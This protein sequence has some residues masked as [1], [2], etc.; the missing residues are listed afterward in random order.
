M[1]A[2]II[3]AVSLLVLFDPGSRQRLQELIHLARGWLLVASIGV[4]LVAVSAGL[5]S[6]RRGGTHAVPLVLAPALPWAVMTTSATAALLDARSTLLQQPVPRFDLSPAMDAHVDAWCVAS[7]FSASCYAL[8]ALLLSSHAARK[9]KDAPTRPSVIEG[10]AA[11]APVVTITSVLVFVVDVGP[12]QWLILGVIPFAITGAKSVRASMAAMEDKNPLWEGMTA[13]ILGMASLVMGWAIGSVTLLEN[14]LIEV[15]FYSLDS[16]QDALEQAYQLAYVSAATIA[17][18]AG[19]ILVLGA[20]QRRRSRSRLPAVG[21]VTGAPAGTS[22]HTASTP[23]RPLI[24]WRRG[25]APALA[26]AALIVSHL[27]ALRLSSLVVSDAS[28]L[29]WVHVKDFVPIEAT[30][31]PTFGLREVVLVTQRRIVFSDGSSAPISALDGSGVQHKLTARFREEPPAAVAA[32]ARLPA[33]I[34]TS[35]TAAAGA[36]RLP[37][38]EIVGRLP[39]GRESLWLSATRVLTAKGTPTDAPWLANR[40]RGSLRGNNLVLEPTQPG[41]I[42]EVVDGTS[43]MVRTEP[44]GIALVDVDD[45]SVGQFLL[46]A[47]GAMNSGIVVVI[48]AAEEP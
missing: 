26:V 28:T 6:V 46:G 27:V 24:A 18:S 44:R 47:R 15:A 42:R 17:L 33:H 11:V 10:I 31:V 21:G 23:K 48:A 2:G 34:L 40:W 25:V 22:A 5:L 16:Q 9:V 4:M 37:A 19:P 3:I 39:S 45:A 1:P 8:V 20:E 30:G 29:P 35:L 41:L 14:Q 43:M 13:I 36:A 32:D 38:V 12:A 7:A